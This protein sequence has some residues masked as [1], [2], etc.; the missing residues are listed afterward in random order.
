MSVSEREFLERLLL[1]HEKRHDREDI[2]DDKKLTAALQATERAGTLQV[3]ELNRRLT[4]L[5]HAHERA[6]EVQQTYVRQDVLEKTIGPIMNDIEGHDAS[7]AE[8]QLELAR[9]KGRYAA[10]GVALF[11]AF[12]IT[13]LAIRFSGA[14]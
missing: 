8:I 3:T 13:S 12:S 14:G 6:V 4:G 2:A 5:N 9:A 1:E 11:I 10:Y 7:I